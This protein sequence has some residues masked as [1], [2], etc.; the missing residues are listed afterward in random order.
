MKFFKD[1][2]HCAFPVLIK[3]GLGWADWAISYLIS[4][5]FQFSCNGNLE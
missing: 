4:Q 3:D 5:N 1:H 2:I